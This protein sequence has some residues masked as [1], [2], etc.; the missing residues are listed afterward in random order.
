MVGFRVASNVMDFGVDYLS[1]RSESEEG[2]IAVWTV[3]ND[4]LERNGQNQSG[5]KRKR[6]AGGFKI[7]CQGMAIRWNRTVQPSL[8]MG[9]TVSFVHLNME[10]LQMMKCT[11]IDH[12]VTVRLSALQTWCSVRL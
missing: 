7:A 3:W 12:H 11:R 6:V 2:N 8:T 10:L 5:L 4:W 9:G 1:L